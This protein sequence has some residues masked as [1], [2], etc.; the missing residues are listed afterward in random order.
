[1]KNVKFSAEISRNLYPITPYRFFFENPTLSEAMSMISRNN[2]LSM[3]QVANRNCEYNWK[4]N[5]LDYGCGNLLW[6]LGLFPDASQITGIEVSEECLE[7]SSLNAHM[8]K[9]KFIPIKISDNDDKNL[10]KI[11]NESFDIALSFVLF[12]IL[13]KKE[14]IKVIRNIKSK[15]RMGG[16]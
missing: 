10:D 5:V 1:M 2:F 8:N 12:E 9:V 11:P 7:F 16:N 13:D 3:K 4:V 15:L 14:I 6:S